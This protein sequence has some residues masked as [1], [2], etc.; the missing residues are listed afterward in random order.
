MHGWNPYSDHNLPKKM[1]LTVAQRLTL[2]SILPEKVGS[3]AE[4]RAIRSLRRLVMPPEA[5]QALGLQQEGNSVRWNVAAAQKIE[6]EEIEVTEEHMQTVGE[7]FANIEASGA[8][9]TDETFISLYDIF[10]DHIPS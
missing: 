7:V 4:M 9:P 10:E 2:L 5:E 3:F 8:V 1:K 6:G